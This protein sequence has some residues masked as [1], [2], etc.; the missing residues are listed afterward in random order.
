MNNY[1]IEIQPL[2]YAPNSLEPYIDALT[3]KLHYG[4]HL[5]SCIDRLNALLEKYPTLKS[6]PLDSLAS[7][8]YAHTSDNDL[9]T[10]G[11]LAGCILNHND[12]FGSLAPNPKPRPRGILADAVK[13]S[14]GGF[15]NM[16]SRFD[17]AARELYGSGYVRLAA[18][19]RG[20]L[21]I[22][23]SPNQDYPTS[24]VT[25]LNLDLWE[26]AYYLKHYNLRDDYIADW[27]HVASWPAAEARYQSLFESNN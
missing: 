13:N 16:K 20:R 14:F 19:R 11:R 7:I 27:W 4:A 15:D 10:I 8:R 3:M 12:F 18:D 22:M 9:V 17:T 6:K 5:Q 21:Y 2:P 23:S 24:V 25:L 26:H 1:S